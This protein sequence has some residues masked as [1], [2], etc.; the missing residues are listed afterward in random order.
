MP[1]TVLALA[2]LAAPAPAAESHSDAA[3]AAIVRAYHSCIAGLDP[4]DRAVLKQRFGAGGAPA[5]QNTDSRAV[6]H[7]IRRLDGAH[8]AGDCPTTTTAS[9]AVEASQDSR[10][11]PPSAT[12]TS[13]GLS[14]TS[15]TELALLALIAAALA[16]LAYGLRRDFGRPRV[17]DWGPGAHRRRW[18]QRRRG[19]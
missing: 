2:A 3:M 19:G 6:L 14:W 9:L 7:A 12:T 5:A 17:A 16:A 4:A 15:P 1:L 18:W 8:R 10:P 11:A 13:T